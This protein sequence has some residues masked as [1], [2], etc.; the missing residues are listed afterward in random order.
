MRVKNKISCN[1]ANLS[2][3]CEVC[4]LG[5]QTKLPFSKSTSFTTRPFQLI[6][7]DLWT[8]SVPS[9]TGFKYYIL[10]LDDY[11]HFLWVYPLKRK[12]DVF[13][14][15]KTFHAYVENQFKT[16]IQALQ[17]DNGGEY[18]NS[19]FQAFFR[20]KG[21]QFRFSCPHT[22]QQN[23]K[24]ERMIRTI[25]N[26]IRCLLFQAH[27]SSSYWVEALHISVHI[28]NI[29]PSSS[30]Q[31]RVPFSILFHK[32]PRYDHLKVF[33]CLCFPNLNYSNLHKLAP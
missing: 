8:S 23:G 19:Q 3:S 26:S 21:I 6:H 1:N 17:C 20:S 10:F 30:V 13:N 5:K 2:S 16:N 15:F 24:S 29:L 32:E 25:N 12:S 22:S 33:G 27:L 28:L 14:E 31:N 18:Q 11:S 7:S 9:I 4:Q